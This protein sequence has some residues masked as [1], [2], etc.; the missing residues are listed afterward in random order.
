M[1][2]QLLTILAGVKTDAADGKRPGQGL[3]MGLGLHWKN[4][5][6]FELLADWVVVHCSPTYETIQSIKSLTVGRGG[7]FSFLAT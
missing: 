4:Y 1:Q 3:L 2:A 5:D 7:T 6:I